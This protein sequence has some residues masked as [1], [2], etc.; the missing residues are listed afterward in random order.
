MER[1]IGEVGKLFNITMRTLRYWDELGLACPSFRDWND[2]RLYTEEDIERIGQVIAYRAVG[3]SLSE[4]Q[5]LLD[6]P[7][8]DSITHLR[9]QR[10]VLIN[11]K[12]GLESMIRALDTLLEDSMPKKL[13]NEEKAE[14]LGEL[15]NPK[16]EEEAFQRWGDSPEW[17]QSEQIKAQMTKAD[18]ERVSAETNALEQRLAD[19]LELGVEPG[20]KEANA[21]AEEHFASIAQWFEMSHDKHVV[22]ARGYTEN[23]SMKAHYDNR[24]DGLAEWLRAIIEANAQANGVDVHNAQWM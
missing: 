21:L 1:T 17:K 13:T 4:I 10:E 22:L 2:Y 23:P 14:I 6:D 11:R 24:A 9:R 8:A 15:W 20:S 18:W 12:T 19:A 3:F 5:T 7:D 16:W